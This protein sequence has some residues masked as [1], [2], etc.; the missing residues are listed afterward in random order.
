MI[1]EY[2]SSVLDREV[3]GLKYILVEANFFPSYKLQPELIIRAILYVATILRIKLRLR[4][5]QKISIEPKSVVH[6]IFK[7]AARVFQISTFH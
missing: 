1:C 6:T 5:N 4:Y 7:A 2:I 3:R